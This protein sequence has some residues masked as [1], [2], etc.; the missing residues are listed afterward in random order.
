MRYFIFVWNERKKIN[1]KIKYISYEYQKD[2]DYVSEIIKN[3]LITNYLITN[4]KT[5]TLKKYSERHDI[6][7][8]YIIKK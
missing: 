8:Y 4:Y 5:D 3:Y 7:N 6:I 2:W 1:N